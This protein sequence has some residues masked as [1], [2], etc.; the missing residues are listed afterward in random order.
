MFATF[1]IEKKLWEQGIQNIVGLDE[2]GRGA[3]AG[4]LVVA[5]VIFPPFIEIDLKLKDSKKLSPLQRTELVYEIKKHAL[6]I[7]YGILPNTYID[8]YG[9]V[10]ATQRAMRD[11]LRKLS[12]QPDF[13]LIDAFS[14]PYIPD[15]KQQPIIRGD[16]LSASIA[17]ASIIAK[18]YR[19]SLMEGY[20]Q[21]DQF[22][23]YGFA[24]HKGY[25]TQKHREAIEKYGICELHR[26]SFVPKNLYA[27]IL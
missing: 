5:A 4:P 2:V 8:N 14:I 6:S 3:W 12:I 25:G 11:A 17:A 18:V 23:N 24:E 22:N 19:D 26:K 13:H 21:K 1:D 20:G 9:I 27:E 16:A 10:K 15:S 7:A